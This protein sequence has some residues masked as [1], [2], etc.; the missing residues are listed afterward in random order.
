MSP[1]PIDLGD[2]ALLRRY[3][4]DDL[5]VLFA[6]VDE[7]RD[8]IGTWMPWP[9]HTRTVEDQRVWLERVVADQDNLDGT[10]LWEDDEYAG[11]VGLSFGPF[12]VTAEIGYWIRA[13]FE[14]R[15]LV[16]RGAR[17][18]TDL[19]FREHGVHRVVIRAGV[20][21][22]RSRAVA[23][24]LGFTFEGVARG[25]GKGAGGF[26]DM[27]VYAILEDEWSG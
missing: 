3:T 19:A 8:R 9:E 26:Y 12:G 14:G 23:E 13:R 27:A 11:G 6:A 1:L 24:R 20:D 22:V 2:G 16:T 18:M 10:G 5:D 21:N 4:L 17:A 25:E 15:G 7:N